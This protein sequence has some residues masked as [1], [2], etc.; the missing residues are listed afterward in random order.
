M[1]HELEYF[2]DDLDP[3]IGDHWVTAVVE[4]P[5]SGMFLVA[6]LGVCNG[7]H[8]FVAKRFPDGSWSAAGTAATVEAAVASASGL[9]AAVVA[10]ST[11]DVCPGP[12]AC[13]NPLAPRYHLA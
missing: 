7:P 12:P 4:T 10:A 8:T 13:T 9:D 5:E 3:V 1:I 6:R 2:F 11:R